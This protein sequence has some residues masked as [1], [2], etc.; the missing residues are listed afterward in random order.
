[1]TGSSARERRALPRPLP[2][3]AVEIIAARL[4]VIGEPMRIRILA[5]LNEGDATVQELT[6]RL[7]TTHQ[8]VS[9]HLGVLY[10]SGMVSRRKEGTSV[11]YALVDWTGWWVVEQIG[12][13]VAA[14]LEDL[15]ELFSRPAADRRA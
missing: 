13:S 10:Q 15:R 4:K 9:K 2:D 11:R 5:L 7:M 8:N 1:V 12:V 6:D 3:E 14:Q